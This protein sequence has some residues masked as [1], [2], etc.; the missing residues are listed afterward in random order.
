MLGDAGRIAL[1]GL[2]PPVYRKRYHDP[3]AIEASFERLIF[4]GVK[5]QPFGGF[6]QRQ[7]VCLGNLRLLLTVQPAQIAGRNT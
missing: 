6:H 2:F 1:Y 5:M 7:N 4:Q 3:W